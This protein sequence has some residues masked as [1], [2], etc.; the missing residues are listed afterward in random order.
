MKTKTLILKSKEG[1]TI[2]TAY[3]WDSERNREYNKTKLEKIHGP[4]KWEDGPIVE[5]MNI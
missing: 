1:K 2:H 4:L 5:T 3:P